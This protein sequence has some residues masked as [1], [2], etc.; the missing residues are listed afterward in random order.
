MTDGGIAFC[1]SRRKKQQKPGSNGTIFSCQGFGQR[2][3]WGDSTLG[4]RRLDRPTAGTGL[5]SHEGVA[6]GKGNH[7][8]TIPQK[9]SHSAGETR[10]SDL[11]STRLGSHHASAALDRV[12]NSGGRLLKCPSASRIRGALRLCSGSAGGPRPCARSVVARWPIRPCSILRYDEFLGGWLDTIRASD[13]AGKE[14]RRVIDTS[15]CGDGRTSLHPIPPG[16]TQSDIASGS[17]VLVLGTPYVRPRAQ[18]RG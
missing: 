6:G 13:P 7:T 2:V 18:G 4:F 11:F 10:T 17:P 15:G 5:K 12:W 16:P 3:C 8:E 9:R 14:E 1:V